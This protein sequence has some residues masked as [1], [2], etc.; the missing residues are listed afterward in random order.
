[1]RPL[2]ACDDDLSVFIL[3][4][5]LLFGPELLLYSESRMRDGAK[6]LLG[7]KFTCDAVYAVGFIFDTHKGSLEAVHEF[8]LSFGK[9]AGLFLA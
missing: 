4:R 1:L 2:V 8:Q 6:T 7:Y 9:M 5:S 3:F